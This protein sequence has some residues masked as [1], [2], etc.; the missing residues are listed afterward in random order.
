[1][2]LR[3]NNFASILCIVCFSSMFISCDNEIDLVADY[4]NIPITYGL[5]D[6]SDTA[7][8]IRVEK[9]FVDPAKSALLLAK[10]PDSL[11]YSDAVVQLKNLATNELYTLERVDGSLEG[12]PRDTGVFATHPNWMYKI[13]TEEMRMNPGDRFEIIIDRGDTYD[14][15][16]ARTK[17]VGDVQLVRPRAGSVIDF[18][19]F[20]DF[21]MVWTEDPSTSFYDVKLDIFISEWNPSTSDPKEVV[22]I[23]W[24][25]GRSIT[26][27]R[28]NVSKREFYAL[29]ASRLEE[30]PSLERSLDS[31]Q[32]TVNSGGEE[33]Y[34]FVRVNLAN[35]GITASQEIPRVTNMSEGFGVFSSKNSISESD[36][37]ISSA[38]YDSLRIG[39]LTQDLNFK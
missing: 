28:L 23:P 26:E 17:I 35:T 12:Y 16:T 21:S 22:V 1:M 34:D 33:L 2:K 36:F 20:G 5:L 27:A 32:L 30:N 37:M 9:A 3:I 38:T 13:R 11:Y 4:K 8:Y 6:R 29:L 10:E 31:F 14:Q 24:V 19:G 15:I 25:L 39:Q 18:S 7:Q